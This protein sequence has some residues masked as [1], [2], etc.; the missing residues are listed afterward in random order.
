[1]KELRQ[2]M[3]V[4]GRG[5]AEAFALAT[6]VSVEGSSYRRPGARLLL[7]AN[8]R[9]VGTISGGCLEDDVISHAQAVLTDGRARTVTYDTKSEND[10][11][12][13]VGL[14][15]HGLVHVL[16]ERLGRHPPWVAELREN[17]GRRVP[18]E[19]AVVWGGPAG[20]PL[21][22]GL[23]DDLPA[24]PAASVFRE[25]VA[26]PVSLVVFGAGD[27]AQPLVRFAKELGWD[28]T[29][30]DPRPGYASQARFPEADS[31]VVSRPEEAPARVA[32][33]PGAVAVIMT[34][35]YAHDVPVLRALLPRPLAYLGLLGPK[36]RSDR[37]LDDL[38]AAG[39]TVTPDMRRRL[40]APVGLDLGANA[41]E[42]V[43]LAI[44]AEVQACLA[45][46]D[47]RPLRER[48]QP[49]HA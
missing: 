8:G 26:P 24:L 35:H 33:G 9:H 46:R 23:A 34:H 40:H 32:L 18:T 28:V 42:T 47:G 15:C 37:I 41:P 45:G 2:I 11:R 3:G 10:L 7:A 31:V 13:G 29:V 5:P 1:M 38:G 21:G 4:L 27:D 14:G 20:T 6:L 12:W 49:I 30:V 22:T 43:A 44:L 16:I 36:H 48:Q 39:F 19:L 17:L 25:T